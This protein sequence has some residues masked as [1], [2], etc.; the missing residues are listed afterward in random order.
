MKKRILGVDWGE[1]R[2]GLSL[3]DALHMTAGPIGHLKRKS[4][5]QDLAGLAGLI[6]ERDVGEIVIGLPLDLHGEKGKAAERVEAFAESVRE[7]FN[8][9]VH[10]WDERMSTKAVEKML[11]EADVSRAKRKKVRDGLSAAYFLQGFLDS[12]QG[13]AGSDE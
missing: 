12:R 8:L 11:I 13:D 4:L 1:K 9:P 7:R 10:M 2:L 3:S 5:E 6:E